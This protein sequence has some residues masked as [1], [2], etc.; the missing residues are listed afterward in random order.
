MAEAPTEHRQE[1][2]WYNVGTSADAARKSA[3]ATMNGSTQEDSLCQHGS[4]YV[5]VDIGQAEVAALEFV[6]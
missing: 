1:C 6:G 3:Y 2:L 4:Q 5:A